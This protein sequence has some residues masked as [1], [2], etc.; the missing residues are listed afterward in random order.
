MQFNKKVFAA[1][2]AITM[3][4]AYVVCAIFVGL[5]PNLAVKFLGWM[6]HLVN[7]N[8]GVRITS[9]SFIGGLLPIVFY[10]YAG[11]WLFAWMYNRAAK[12]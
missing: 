11:A 7:I 8:A 2:A 3:A 9:G 12:R 6:T 10:S 4:V 5:F 1:S